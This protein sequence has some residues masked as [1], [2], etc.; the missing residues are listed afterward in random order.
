MAP[1][2]TVLRCRADGWSIFFRLRLLSHSLR[3]KCRPVRDG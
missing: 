1:L 3:F 2:R